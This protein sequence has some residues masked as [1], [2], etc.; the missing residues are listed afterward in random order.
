[1][2]ERITVVA[3]RIVGSWAAVAVAGLDV[4]VGVVEKIGSGLYLKSR[5]SPRG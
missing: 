5:T 1:V 3:C 4:G 2:R